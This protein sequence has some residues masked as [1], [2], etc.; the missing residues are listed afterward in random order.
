MRHTGQAVL[1]HHGSRLAVTLNP[2][3]I[4]AHGL[5]RPLHPVDAGLRALTHAVL[6]GGLHP[7]PAIDLHGV[8]LLAG[9]VRT[10]LDGVIHRH[11]LSN[12]GKKTNYYQVTLGTLI[13]FSYR[14]VV[15]SELPDGRPGGGGGHC[16][17]G[18]HHRAGVGR[19]LKRTVGS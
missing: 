7:P 17:A 16:H 2:L 13:V 12:L 11:H 1:S 10:R 4:T 8:R 6:H 5:R 19:H 14:D 18:G 9:A 15:G 3:V